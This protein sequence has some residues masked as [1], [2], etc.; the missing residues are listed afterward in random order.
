MGHPTAR[1]KSQGNTSCRESTIQPPL[2]PRAAST[3][4]PPEQGPARLAFTSVIV[5]RCICIIN[6]STAQFFLC[7]SGLFCLFPVQCQYNITCTLLYLVTLK[8]I[9]LPPPSQA[10]HHHR[11]GARHT[12]CCLGGGLSLHDNDLNSH[13]H[14]HTKN[15]NNTPKMK[16]KA[17]N[18]SYSLKVP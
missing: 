6:S 15:P 8:T 14:T 17:L 16:L 2:L 10:S 4:L 11:H 12:G 3:M 1:E 9:P 13:T 5:F 18:S 7:T